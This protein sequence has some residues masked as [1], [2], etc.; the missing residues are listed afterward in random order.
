[1][2]NPSRQNS[3]VHASGFPRKTNKCSVCP[4]TEGDVFRSRSNITLP[5]KVMHVVTRSFCLVNPVLTDAPDDEVA[6]FTFR[7]RRDPVNARREDG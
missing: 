3:P 5:R 6:Y 1:V 7:R 2:V 4:F